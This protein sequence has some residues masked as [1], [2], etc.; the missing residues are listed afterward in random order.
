[1]IQKPGSSGLQTVETSVTE[2][3]EEPLTPAQILRLVDVGKAIA[4]HYGRP[5]D[6]EFCFTR[7]SGAFYVVQT[8][9]VTSFQCTGIKGYWYSGFAFKSWLA[10][11]M[12]SISGYLRSISY[13]SKNM[14]PFETDESEFV[15]P[16]FGT[17]YINHVLQK[18]RVEENKSAQFLQTVHESFR[19]V[20][21]VVEHLQAMEPHLW[22]LLTNGLSQITPDDF[23]DLLTAMINE[24]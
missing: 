5:Q 23:S 6:I 4:C 14:K 16:F 22:W 10:M 1:M 2:R 12:S 19:M 9:P 8:R 18:L 20:Q 17:A 24:R 21:R 15:R 11:S 3:A 7:D 13:G